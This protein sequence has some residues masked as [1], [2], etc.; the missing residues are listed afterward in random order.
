MVVAPTGVVCL[1][2]A[3]RLAEAGAVL[4]GGT[5]ACPL[6]SHPGRRGGVD[7]GTRACLI[8]ATVRLRM[9]LRVILF[10]DT[11]GSHAR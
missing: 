8:K 6:V 2:L 4:V 9:T 5:T 10:R 7:N 3:R 1:V 11:R